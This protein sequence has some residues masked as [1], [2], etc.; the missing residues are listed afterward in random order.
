MM[1][2][3]PFEAAKARDQE[4]SFA[5]VPCESGDTAAILYTSG[6]TGRPKGA[7]LTHLNLASNAR[8]LHDYWQWT[9]SDVLL[10]AVPLFSARPACGSV[11]VLLGLTAALPRS[12]RRLLGWRFQWPLTAWRHRT[13]SRADQAPT[14]GSHRPHRAAVA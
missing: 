10:P 2:I 14:R 6:T 4:P 9:P 5:T 7:M 11:L 1:I 8:A 12:T 3:E 13:R